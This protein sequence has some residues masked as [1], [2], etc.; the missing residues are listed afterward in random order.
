MVGWKDG[1]LE[2]SVASPPV[3]GAANDELVRLLAATLGVARGAVRIA[4]GEH[5][6]N[7]LVEVDGWALSELRAKLN[8]AP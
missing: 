8:G 3:E 2:V 5:S 1:V 6:R 7:K 4:S